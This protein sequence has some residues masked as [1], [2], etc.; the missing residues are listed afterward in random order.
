MAFWDEAQP[1][2]DGSQKTLRALLQGLFQVEEPQGRGDCTDRHTQT[3]LL[4]R[5]MAACTVNQK[6]KE[7]DPACGAPLS[8]G[9]HAGRGGSP[10][11]NLSQAGA[12]AGLG[13]PAWGGHR[14]HGAWCQPRG[15]LRGWAG[16]VLQQQQVPQKHFAFMVLYLNGMGLKE[17]DVFKNV[18]ISLLNL[19]GLSDW[20]CIVN[21]E[22][23]LLGTKKDP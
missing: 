13:M 2:S 3:E 4:G 9:G 7:T 17:P 15:G 10:Q 1:F 8:R 11:L 19:T 20:K 5:S 18:C 16:Q 12:G 23:S 6:Q 21:W 22:I 14:A